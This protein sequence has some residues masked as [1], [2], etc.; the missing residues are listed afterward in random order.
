MAGAQTWESESS[1][2]ETCCIFVFEAKSCPLCTQSR[3]SE[4]VSQ[5]A[6]AVWSLSTRSHGSS[7]FVSH[8]EADQRWLLAGVGGSI[9]SS[10]C[11][12]Q[13]W[14]LALLQGEGCLGFTNVGGVRA[15]CGCNRTTFTPSSSMGVEIATHPWVNKLRCS[16]VQ[17]LESRS[18][19]LRSS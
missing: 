8:P 15:R 13:A 17:S 10:L 16:A 7:S 5:G 11:C 4:K 3:S 14:P 19:P 18:H 12:W 9:L 2:Q 1:S 6:G